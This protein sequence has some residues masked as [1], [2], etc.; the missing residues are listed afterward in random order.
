MMLRASQALRN[1]CPPLRRMG[2]NL[3]L[4]LLTKTIQIMNKCRPIQDVFYLIMKI[5]LTQVLLMVIL[6]SLVSA[7]HLNGQGI[8]D[9]KVSLDAE[10][11]TIKAILTEI[12]KQTSVVFT[13]R[14]RLINDSK[15][16]NFKITD[17]KLAEVLGQLFGSDISFLPV[18]EEEEVVLRPAP[19]SEPKGSLTDDNALFVLAV[20]GT[21]N[22][23]TGQPLPGVNVV[24]KGTTNGTTTDVSGMFTLNVQD[25]RSVLVFSFIG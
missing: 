1:A 17:A 13:Y 3:F 4:S 18:N 24:E 8:L 5:T 7:S 6:T 20:S 10:N 9:R 16:V 19:K 11:T 12:E 21:V 14:P 25:E 2:L 22:D 15:K 23:E